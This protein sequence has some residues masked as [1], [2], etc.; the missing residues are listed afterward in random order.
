MLV[1]KYAVELVTP[2]AWVGEQTAPAAFLEHHRAVTKRWAEQLRFQRADRTAGFLMFS[3]ECWFRHSYEPDSIQPYPVVAAMKDAWA[4]VGLAIETGRR[5][6]FSG[7]KLETAVF[8]TNDD[9]QFRDYRNLELRV[10]GTR[11]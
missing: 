1:K 11:V 7:E 5:R 10:N 3:V 9:E 2:Q 8:V 4:P 6:F